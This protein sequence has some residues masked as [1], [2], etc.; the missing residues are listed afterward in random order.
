VVSFVVELGSPPPSP[1]RRRNHHQH[2]R[3]LV[4]RGNRSDRVGTATR[5]Q[6]RRAAFSWSASP[7]PS[8]LCSWQRT[9]GVRGR[10]SALRPGLSCWRPLCTSSLAYPAGRLRTR[11]DRM[12]VMS[13]YALAIASNLLTL[14]FD[15]HAGVPEV[16]AE[17]VLLVADKPTVAHG[18]WRPLPM[19]VAALSDRVGR[20]DPGGAVPARRRPVARACVEADRPCRRDGAHLPSR[21]ASPPAPIDQDVK[22]RPRHHR[23]ARARECA[24]LVPGRGFLAAVS[25]TWRCLR[26]S[27]STCA[28]QGKPRGG[29]GPAYVER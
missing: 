14:L 19:S 25:R 26:N 2:G 9:T 17:A 16:H 22:R 6:H 10:R 4:V 20:R 7:G 3:R 15:P 28:R 8:P 18:G 27:C 1:K 12:I 13:G 21:R 23:P 24:F 5:K 29:P 11:V